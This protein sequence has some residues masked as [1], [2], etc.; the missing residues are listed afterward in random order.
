MRPLGILLIVLCLA[1][2]NSTSSAHLKHTLSNHVTPP[3]KLGEPDEHMPIWTILNSGGT[4]I[5]Y[6]FESSKLAPIP[7]FSGT[8]M[9][10]LVAIDTEG[11]FIEVNV[12]DQ[13][14]PVFV[15]GLGI[16]PFHDFVRQYRGKSL[17]DSIKIIPTTAKKPTTSGAETNNYIDGITKATASVRIANETIL[18][19]SLKVA[20]EKLANIATRPAGRPRMDL[21]QKMGWPSLVRSG[22]LKPLKLDNRTVQ[23]AFVDTIFS[24]DDSE[25]AERPNDPYLDLWVADLGIPSVAKNILTT[26][27]FNTLRNQFAREEEPILMLANG[28]H[29]LVSEEFIRNTVPD[30]I[31]IRQ[32]GFPISM[33]DADVEIELRP[34]LPKFDQV[35][36]LR[37]DTRYGFDPSSPWDIIISAVR[38]HGYFRPAIGSK[39]FTLSYQ[40]DSRYFERPTSQATSMP[41]WFSSWLEKAPEILAILLFLVILSYG[42]HSHRSTV[43]RPRRLAFLLP[44]MLLITLLF[45]GWYIQGQLSIVTLLGLFRSIFQ[46]QNFSFLLYDPISLVLW[47]YVIFSLALWGRGTFC[48]WLCPFGTLQE[49]AHQLGQKV[50]VKPMKISIKM[51]QKLGWIK[52][53]VL[54]ILV[55]SIFVPS[56]PDD[57]LVEVEPF[58]TS[59]TMI[60]QRSW[61]YLLYALLCILSSIF[62]FKGY[63]RFICPLGAALIVGGR[64]RRLDWLV[65]RQECGNPCQY[66]ATVCQ[67]DAINLHDGSI[68]YDDCF[69]C[70]KCVEIYDDKKRCVPLTQ[71]QKA[72][73]YL[74]V[75]LIEE[76]PNL[77][78]TT[79][80]RCIK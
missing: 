31:A 47:V 11:N 34:D 45:I 26:E 10:L 20:R 23:L 56:L 7:G 66:C 64:I 67:Y 29:R 69:Q 63:C 43:T 65:R 73:P 15:S 3:M 68:N 78:Y 53:A 62:L 49:F 2:A 59:I 27:S 16:R 61:P 44:F 14:E 77:I 4:L 76:L 22:L 75:P 5:G 71:N 74:S 9:N 6:I 33:R 79:L 8:P 13:N 28:H 57:R 30:Q 35:M 60:F 36:V 18:A 58:K 38:K 12:L 70:L 32:Q 72:S 50:G 52:F 55:I 17:A 46:T 39:S 19:A 37:V 54:A 1:W 41:R 40:V 25:A 51:K 24:D 21:Y 80:N 48:G 42:L